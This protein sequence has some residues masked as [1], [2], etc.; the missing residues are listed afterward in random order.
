MTRWDTSIWPLPLTG[1]VGCRCTTGSAQ[2]SLRAEV[3]AMVDPMRKVL[4]AD[5][6]GLAG[7]IIFQKDGY[8]MCRP[9]PVAF[10]L[11][12]QLELLKKYGYQV[13]TVQRLME[14]SPLCRCGPGGPRL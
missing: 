8:N 14:Y 4:E 6:D 7:Q 5:P 12:K 2:E 1:R 10:G 13:V 11:K 3:E 9:D